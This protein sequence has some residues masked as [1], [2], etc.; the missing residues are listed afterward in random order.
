MVLAPKTVFCYECR[1][2][3]RTKN[4]CRA[5]GKAKD[6]QWQTPAGTVVSISV[7]TAPPGL[8]VE[9]YSQ[10]VT[11]AAHVQGERI[12]SQ[13][14]Y[15][16]LCA[17][18][19]GTWFEL[20]RHYTEAHPV[21]PALK[22]VLRSQCASPGP[23]VIEDEDEGPED[24]DPIED[25]YAREINVAAAEAPDDIHTH[26]T[27]AMD[28]PALSSVSDDA[29]STG[30]PRPVVVLEYPAA[31]LAG[32][33]VDSQVQSDNTSQL[34]TD[35]PRTATP[36]TAQSKKAI[37]KAK[38]A[39]RAAKDAMNGETRA[40]KKAR[41]A[42]ASAERKAK[43]AAERA[44]REESS[45]AAGIDSI[46]AIKDQIATLKK[47]EKSLAREATKIVDRLTAFH[48]G[49]LSLQHS[50]GI[51]VVESEISAASGAPLAAAITQTEDIQVN[52]SD[53]Q[54]LRIFAL[55][56]GVNMSSKVRDLLASTEMVA[57][58]SDGL[59]PGEPE[60]VPSPTT[61]LPKSLSDS[62]EKTVFDELRGNSNDA[63]DAEGSHTAERSSLLRCR[64]CLK[65]V[66]DEPVATPCGH[67]FCHSCI[68]KELIAHSKC[69]VCQRTVLQRLA[70]D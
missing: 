50:G 5:H 12:T 16:P 14:V 44:A 37:K 48:D 42:A 15:C 51:G 10:V 58:R 41:K 17:R 64:L 65:N 8:V 4:G 60:D 9:L 29:T 66:C 27:T 70:L 43:K 7:P 1:K 55:R 40:E 36:V 28:I 46:D 52:L 34:P 25:V 47:N 49:V 31:E 39:E 67:V 57:T 35:A 11:L 21:E 53:E 30:E 56:H 20:N 63:E 33:H 69:P 2:G 59:Q 24:V 19:W 3:F 62:W 23:L 61:S 32:K 54:L 6:H 22:D 18:R 13:F 38:R 68:G 45:K 26:P